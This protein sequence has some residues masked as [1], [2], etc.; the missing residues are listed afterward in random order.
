M[1]KNAGSH[2][3]DTCL[4]YL[5]RPRNRIISNI[6]I[7]MASSVNPWLNISWLN[8]IADCDKNYPIVI[9]NNVL[10]FGSQYKAHINRKP[11]G[12]SFDYFPE[13]FW[14]DANSNVYCLNMNPGELD[15][16]FT[17]ANDGNRV[18]EKYNQDVLNHR[19]RDDGC[20]FEIGKP[21]YEN[22]T[23]RDQILDAY[24]ATPQKQRPAKKKVNPRPHL[25]NFWHREMWN[26]LRRQ[27]RRDPK[28]FFIE[29]FPY[30]SNRGFKFPDYLPSY[31]YRNWLVEEAMNTGKMIIIMRKEEEWYNIKDNNIGNRLRT[32]SNKLLLKNR[33]RVWLSQGNLVNN[34]TNTQWQHLV[35]L[36]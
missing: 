23:L 21:I 27:L 3:Y 15:P 36:F 26:S 12:L 11:V 18:V 34:I 9:N 30:H 33:Q 17:Q 29:Y 7:I 25:G 5:C 31:E 32:Y 2:C 13:P 20:I 10:L 8:T 6:Q 28:I 4:L 1:Q 14:G 19:F 22:L 16:D 35:N 24:F